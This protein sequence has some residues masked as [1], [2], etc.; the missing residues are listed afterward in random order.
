[1]VETPAFPRLPINRSTLQGTDLSGGHFEIVA[2]RRGPTD[3][4]SIQASRNGRR[5]GAADLPAD[6][7]PDADL[8]TIAIS[9]GRN[10][11]LI[12]TLRYG[13]QR[14]RC[15]YNDDGRDRVAIYFSGTAAP[16]IYPTSFEEIC[17]RDG[18]GQEPP[19]GLAR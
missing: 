5:I 4:L 16:A 13:R 14:E 15:F 17:R 7:F 9:Q 12:V 2:A 10:N 3:S 1:M 19:A 8:N 6:R 18:S 11:Q